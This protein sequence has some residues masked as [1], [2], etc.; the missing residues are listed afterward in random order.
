[1]EQNYLFIEQ[2]PKNS[3]YPWF[4]LNSFVLIYTPNILNDRLFL[5]NFFNGSLFFFAFTSPSLYFG[6]Q[7]LSQFASIG[8][9]VIVRDTTNLIGMK[10]ELT[11]ILIGFC[12]GRMFQNVF[13][14][15]YNYVF[16]PKKRIS[17]HALGLHTSNSRIFSDNRVRNIISFL[18][19]IDKNNENKFFLQLK[20]FL[21]KCA[22]SI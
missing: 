18:S 9:S 20:T 1:M 12:V 15:L 10:N 17:C 21:R 22:S 19:Q 6:S 16:Q 7:N 8:L 5:K 13:E 4:I 11:N 14:K 3:N 2:K